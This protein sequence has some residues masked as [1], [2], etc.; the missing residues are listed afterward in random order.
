MTKSIKLTILKF[1]VFFIYKLQGHL[2]NESR[3]L[4]LE[5]NHFITWFYLKEVV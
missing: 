4:L 2:Y 5:Q 3:I 1:N